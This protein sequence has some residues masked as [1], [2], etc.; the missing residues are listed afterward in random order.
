M[1]LKKITEEYYLSH[2]FKNLRDE[3]KAHYKYCLGNVMT[4]SIDDIIL[5]E[6]DV[7]QV[8]TKQAKLAYDL[9]CD[10]GIS[11]ANH[12][13]ATARMVFNYAV[14]ME[15]CNI[16]P[17]TTVRRRATQP[18]KVVWTKGDVRKL[19]DAAYSD[20]STRNIGLIAHMAY[21]WCQRVGDMRM[22]TWDAIDFEKKRVVIQQSKRNAQVELPID[23]DL[24][25]MLIQQEQD[26]GFQQ[27]VAPRPVSYRGVY[28]PYSMYKLPL[29]ARKLMDDA[30]LSKDLR[31][32]DLR[33]TGVTEMVDAE[34]GIGQIM[35]VTGHANP[36]SVKPYLKNTYVSANNALTARKN[37]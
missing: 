9:W 17:F 34:V 10:R 28:E 22:L 6:V 16:N 35:S 32:S 25:D 23:D 11:F 31:L 12:I 8:S 27:Y 13:M 1:K 36:Q 15:H 2:D 30:G 20:F 4:T 18:R 7:S 37:S 29:H 19:L 33:R 26:F 5:G 21:E 3:T 24:L 14:R